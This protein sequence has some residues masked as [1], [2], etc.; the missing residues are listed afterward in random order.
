MLTS[1]GK[2]VPMADWLSSL[3]G[4]S[5]KTFVRRGQV[6]AEDETLVR[7]TVKDIARAKEKLPILEAVGASS[8]PTGG[9][10]FVFREPG[11]SSPKPVPPTRW[12]RF[13]D[14]APGAADAGGAH[15]AGASTFRAT[16]PS[17][18]RYQPGSA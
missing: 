16:V 15:R 10:R 6:A 7:I 2:H 12:Q 8:H 11:A 17:G 4:L 13:V 5:V 3:E 14:Y 1:T 9:S 18:C